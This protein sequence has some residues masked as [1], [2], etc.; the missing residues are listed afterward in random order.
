VKIGAQQRAVAI[1]DCGYTL[2]KRK[3]ARMFRDAI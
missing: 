3:P 1:L 2:Q